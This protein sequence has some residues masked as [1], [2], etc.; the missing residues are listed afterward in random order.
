MGYL[1]ILVGLFHKILFGGSISRQKAAVK[2]VTLCSSLN[3]PD[4][5]A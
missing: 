1:G 4:A 5:Q 2:V 3:A